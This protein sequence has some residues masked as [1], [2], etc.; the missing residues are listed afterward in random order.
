MSE[1]YSNSRGGPIG[2]SAETLAHQLAKQ[3]EHARI[4]SWP[5]GFEFLAGLLEFPL[6][7]GGL[8]R[9]EIGESSRR[10]F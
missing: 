8:S 3:A 7:D 1:S 10:W 6:I 9:F 2:R 4:I 5:Q